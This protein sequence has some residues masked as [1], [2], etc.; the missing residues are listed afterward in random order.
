ME[1]QKRIKVN[2]SLRRTEQVKFFGCVSECT[3]FESWSQHIVSVLEY[4]C[5]LHQYVQADAGV[6][7][8]IGH[9]RFLHVPSCFV[10]TSS[11]IRRSKR[12][13]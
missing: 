10:S 9:D 2:R 11:T 8:L 12:Y 5:T 13:T 6:S 3:G 7:H 1:Y 4:F